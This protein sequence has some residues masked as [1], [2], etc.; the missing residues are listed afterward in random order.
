MYLFLNIFEKVLMWRGMFLSVYIDSYGAFLGRKRNRFY[1]SVS[2]CSIRR[3]FVSS[4]VNQIVFVGLGKSLSVDA[5]C[6]AVK[7]RIPV[8]FSWGNGFPYAAVFPMVAS[9][10][11]ERRRAQYAGFNDWRGVELAK[12]FV[13]GKLIN[14]SNVLK[15]HYKVRRKRNPEKAMLLRGL[16]RGIDE[17]VKEVRELE[18]GNVSSDFQ[19]VLI[20]LEAKAARFFYWRGFSEIL[21]L[22]DVFP[23]RVTRGARDPVNSL[24]NYGYGCLLS[25]VMVAVFYAGLDPYAGFLHVDRP[26]RP[27][28]VLDLMEEFRQQVVDRVVISLLDRG[29][30]KISEVC[31]KEESVVEGDRRTLSDRA[32]KVLSEALEARFSRVVPCLD[33]KSCSLERCI[34]VQARRVARFLLGEESFYRPFTLGW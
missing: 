23:G 28:L 29:V 22:G 13:L 16:A 31:L 6:L 9:G 14:Q 24:L 12:G 21:G 19:S 8:F 5:L 10:T 34:H 17:V 25:R 7:E 1:V 18:A 4:D 30:L 32:V 11:V 33:G 26:G 2:G 20:G 15:M 3:E 27:S